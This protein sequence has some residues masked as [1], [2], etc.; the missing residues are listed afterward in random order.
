M[1]EPA[2]TDDDVESTLTRTWC[3]KYGATN[4]RSGIGATETLLEYDLVT[5]LDDR[6][7][8][9]MSTFVCHARQA[10]GYLTAFAL[11]G[12]NRPECRPADREKLLTFLDAH[13][14]GYLVCVSAHALI[15][16][17]ID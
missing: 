14:D 16:G 4:D 13:P 2:D 6:M 7:N 5:E 1:N 9:R 3:V 17:F 10:R 11:Q 15:G 12:G 8:S